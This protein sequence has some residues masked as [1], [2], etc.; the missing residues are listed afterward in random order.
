MYDG[1]ILKESLEDVSVLS[2]DRIRIS[3]ERIWKVGSR[4]VEWQPAEWTAIYVEGKDED[5]Q[6]CATAISNALLE[7]WYA[8]LSNSTTE[9]VVFRNRIFS[10]RKGDEEAKEEAKN[11]AKLMGIPEHQ[12]NW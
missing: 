5:I 8:N 12:L 10:Y 3:K 9:Y 7:K 4:A 11:Y 6:Y 1:L 2:N